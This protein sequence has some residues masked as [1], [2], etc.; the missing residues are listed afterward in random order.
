LNAYLQL[1]KLNRTMTLVG[2]PSKPLAVAPFSLIIRHRQLAGST[3]GGIRETQE[4]L[5]FCGEQGIT[6]D[7]ELIGI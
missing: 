5:H 6:S 1:L 3:I 7:I 2:A 4:M